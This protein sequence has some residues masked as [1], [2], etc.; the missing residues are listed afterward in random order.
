MKH[1]AG[2]LWATIDP[3]DKNSEWVYHLSSFQPTHFTKTNCGIPYGKVISESDSLTDVDC[4]NCLRKVQQLFESNHIALYE[5]GEAYIACN[6]HVFDVTE[7]VRVM[8]L[9]EG[10]I[11]IC[12]HAN[13]VRANMAHIDCEHC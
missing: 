10:F 7:N 4:P 5:L 3:A 12:R 1:K 11:E 8:L 2:L 9:A 13:Y 6:G